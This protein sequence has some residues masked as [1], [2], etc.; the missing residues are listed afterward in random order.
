VGLAE[1]FLRLGCVLVAWMMLYA[2][3]LWLAALYAM[4]CGPDGDEL[5]RVLLGLAPVTVAFAYLLRVTRPFA[6]IHS[7]LRWLAIPLLLLL[8]FVGRS[9]WQVF[10]TVNLE[11][12]ALCANGAPQTWQ[13]L[14]TPIQLLT[15]LLVAY[16]VLNVWRSVRLDAVANAKP[17]S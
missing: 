3:I 16:M 9:L 11:G 15:L 12:S 4:G 8:P 1:V 6:E 13:I 7:M 5:H 17:E 2:H 14:W 10:R